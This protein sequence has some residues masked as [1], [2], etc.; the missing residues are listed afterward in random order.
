MSSVSS[1]RRIASRSGSRAS[2][3]APAYIRMLPKPIRTWLR[4]CGSPLRVAS[5][6]ASRKKRGCL[7]LQITQAG[8]VN[9]DLGARSRSLGEV[10]PRIREGIHELP[11]A[12]PMAER[13]GK[14]VESHPLGRPAMPPRR[15]PS[16]CDFGCGRSP[17]VGSTSARKRHSRLARTLTTSP[18][19]RGAQRRRSGRAAQ[20]SLLV[21]AKGDS[22]QNLYLCAGRRDCDVDN[23]LTRGHFRGPRLA[24][25]AK[26]SP[27]PVDR[28]MP[29]I[30]GTPRL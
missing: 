6:R 7:V 20:R 13:L 17:A 8:E 11:H 2:A 1:A 19:L 23:V 9:H 15:F 26:D 25:L 30:Q 21:Q 5:S 16:I 27:A 29:D 14:I 24:Q 4:T 18:T 10:L 22:V 28:A 12:L 3:T